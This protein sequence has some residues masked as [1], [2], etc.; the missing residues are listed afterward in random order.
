MSYKT[1]ST[2]EKQR[3][4]NDLKERVREEVSCD[5]ILSR[6]GCE[7]K[8]TEANGINWYLSPFRDEKT[9]SFKVD[10]ITNAYIDFGEDAK[11]YNDVIGLVMRLN[12]TGG[13][14]FDSKYAHLQPFTQAVLYLADIGGINNNN[15]VHR[16]K[17]IESKKNEDYKKP[18]KRETSPN[19]ILTKIEELK[20][21]SLINYFVNERKIKESVVQKFL[22]EVRYSFPKYPNSDF[23][24]AGFRNKSG[25]YELRSPPTKNNPKGFK[26]A[27]SPKDITLIKGQEP[28]LSVD[29]WE[30]FTDMMTMCDMKNIES[31]TN[32]TVVMNSTALAGATLEFLLEMKT[33]RGNLKKI[34]AYFDN[35][36]AGEEALYMLKYGARNKEQLEEATKR[37][38][39][40]IGLVDVGVEVISQ[41][42]F[43]YPNNKDLNEFHI[44]KCTTQVIDTTKDNVHKIK[45]GR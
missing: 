28:T 22:V 38:S 41:A 6:I 17:K 37:D 32:N 16:H 7:I 31:P 44:Q 24:S 45:L 26:G 18:T 27:T 21:R 30:G 11:K 4:F 20:N 43:L 12:S 14:A 42:E 1:K 29:V 34:Y 2:A 40:P 10:T 13:I 33:K 25:G 5:S 3:D 9:A 23:F 19:I 8:K 15:S 35:D 39:K 36:I